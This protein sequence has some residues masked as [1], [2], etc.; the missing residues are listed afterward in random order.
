[1]TPGDRV[2]VFDTDGTLMDGRV[3]VLDAVAEALTAT[4]RHFEL[5]VPP[6]DRERIGLAMG[7]PASLFFRTAFDPDSVPDDLRDVFV[8]E[9]EVKST[10]AEVAAL[11]RGGSQLY[12]G[13]GDTLAALQARGFSLALYSNAAE[14]YFQTVIEVH[15]LDRWF[16]R[17]LSLEYAVRRRLAR[18]K[19]GM[20]RH[21]SRGY[22]GVVVVGDRIHDIEAGQEA[23][24]VTVGCRFGF[25]DPGELSEADWQIDRLD[26]LLALPCLHRDDHHEARG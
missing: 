10:R 8:S 16:T 24:A 19:A 4:Y 3:A 21:L 17:T 18:D 25:G 7:L 23:G 6:P 12:A 20:V 15:G 22:G 13:A 26:D 14:P 9:F 11:R 5:P 1:M 2:I